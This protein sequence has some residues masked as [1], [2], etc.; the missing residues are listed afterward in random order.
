MAASRRA[1]GS[2]P[3]SNASSISLGGN[4]K[5]G[6]AGGAAVQQREYEQPPQDDAHTPMLVSRPAVSGSP[7]VPG[8]GPHTA[9]SGCGS[10]SGRQSSMGRSIG[11]FGQHHGITPGSLSAARPP[12]G[13]TAAQVRASMGWPSQPSPMLLQQ[14]QA[15]AQL[16]VGG[17]GTTHGLPSSP[18]RASQQHPAPWESSQAFSL[19]LGASCES[20]FSLTASMVSSMA[21]AASHALRRSANLS[22]AAAAAIAS[23]G[24]QQGSPGHSGVGRRSLRFQNSPGSLGAPLL[25]SSLSGLRGTPCSA[26][27]AA[28]A[29]TAAPSSSGAVV[30]PFAGAASVAATPP[31]LHSP[32]LHLGTVHSSPLRLS[33]QSMPLLQARSIQSR[34]NSAASSAGQ[35][36]PPTAR[37][38]HDGLQQQHSQQSPGLIPG[39]RVTTQRSG[40]AD[41][42]APS[43][44]AAGPPAPAAAA[45]AQAAAAVEFTADGVAAG[46]Q[47]P[48][49]EGAQA[50]DPV[51]QAQQQP[52]DPTGELFTP[53]NSQPS[54]PAAAISKTGRASSDTF[55]ITTSLFTN[56]AFSPASPVT[57]IAGILHGQAPEA[58]ADMGAAARPAGSSATG[59]AASFGSVLVAAGRDALSTG[60]RSGPSL[61]CGSVGATPAASIS[62]AGSLRQ[63][64]GAGDS[65][66]RASSG[67]SLGGSLGPATVQARPTV[68]RAQVARLRTELAQHRDDS[69]VS[70]ELLSHELSRRLEVRTAPCMHA[71]MHDPAPEMH[72]A[73]HYAWPCAYMCSAGDL[74]IC[75]HACGSWF[76][77]LGA[78]FVW[79]GHGGGGR[80]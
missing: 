4:A 75:M 10:C 76:P 73:A 7:A 65:L 64:G 80:S 11:G 20:A 50:A 31:P 27:A 55:G 21:A 5:S 42:P 43:P 49:Q 14:Q 67:A 79:C 34:A 12:L 23:S 22:P 63:G 13:P 26:G 25:R 45:E 18:E 33:L 46:Q 54:T 17:S 2:H 72:G 71:C 48:R 3:H 58:S 61:A 30:S 9:A 47:G 6:T 59:A 77:L 62:M 53:D 41:A 32:A 28:L 19:N 38:W 29:H 74:D 66:L 39:L 60:A 8:S 70:E 37:P 35:P 16:G 78:S 36:P 56:P 68:L 57:P 44:G 52:G 24:A 69:S 51:V 40:S 15:V 1:S